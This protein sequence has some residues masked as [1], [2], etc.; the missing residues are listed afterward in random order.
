MADTIKD[1]MERNKNHEDYAK[2]LKQ[3]IIDNNS[4]ISDLNDEIV[5]YKELL[6]NA[7]L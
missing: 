7:C 6:Q 5:R 2:V 4:V 1:I 3:T